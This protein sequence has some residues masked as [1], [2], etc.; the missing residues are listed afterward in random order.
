VATHQ[1]AGQ[2]FTHQLLWNSAK[3]LLSQPE[4]QT[5]KDGYFR[6]AGMLMAYFTFEA[7]LNL[8]GPR[9]DPEAWKNERDF[10]NDDPYR[11]TDGKLKRISEKIGVTLP[12][13]K[14]PYQTIRKLKRLRD[15]LAHGRLESYAYE[16]ELSGDKTP[17][18]FGGLTIYKWT[19]RSE[20]ELALNDTQELI[21][22]LHTNIIKALHIDDLP[23]A[24]N[25]LK[26]PLAFA[27]GGEKPSR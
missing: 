2:G 3:T 7:Y 19:S 23:F 18:M 12:K 16:I 6:M 21:Q 22:F 15:F 26:F 1:I 27:E 10:F 17:D 20:A 9:V 13:G 4:S 14:R 8:V 24:G 11:G 5:P 25:P